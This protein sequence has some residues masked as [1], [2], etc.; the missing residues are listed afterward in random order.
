MRIITPDVGGAFGAKFGADAEH[1]VICWIA[2]QLG[3]P[4]RWSETRNENLLVMPH[5]RAQEQKVT[6]G[7]MK[8]GTVLAYRLE[9][10][11]DCGAYPKAGAFLPC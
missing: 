8:D 11:Q 5:G 3:R 10:L 9:I 7:G 6:I 2:K 4:V 1:A